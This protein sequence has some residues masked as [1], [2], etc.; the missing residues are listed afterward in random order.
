MSRSV[1]RSLRRGPARS[2]SFALSFA[3]PLALA[4]SLWLA[5]VGSCLY[6]ED[7]YYCEDMPNHY[8]AEA[9][10]ATSADCG[11]EAP[12][13]DRSAATGVCVQC[14]TEEASACTGAAP[15]CGDD[16]SCRGCARHGECASG[17]CLPDGACADEAQ[18]AYLA[19]GGAGTACTRGAPCANVATALALNK[20]VVK[21]SGTIADALAL[22]GGRRLTW[23]AEP[24]ARL[25]GPASG[26]LVTVRD[27]GTSLAMFDVT[28]AD[29]NDEAAGYGLLVAVDAGDVAVALQR[30]TV[31]NNRAGAISFS[32]GS[33]T[34][35]AS[36][37]IGNPGGG[38]AIA[39]NATRFSVRDSVLAYNGSANG[40]ASGLEPSTVGGVAI[41]AN[42]QGSDLSRNTIVYNQSDGATF[43]GGVSCNAPRATASGNLIFRNGEPDGAGDVRYDLA[44]QR[45]TTSACAYGNSLALASDAQNLGFASPLRPPLDFH[46]TAATPATVRDAGGDCSGRD[47]DGDPRP[48][49]GACDLG[50]D[51]YRPE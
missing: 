45:N 21:H 50:A 31:R 11:D 13:C 34:I 46:L 19:E 51:E 36:T 12:V 49:G 2:L 24:G 43:R 37:L 38:L 48:L 14:T 41:T 32:A 39:G 15:I 42:T 6:A 22:A 3:L 10:C 40:N 28:L 29:A 16:R 4:V 17:A 8:C 5:L 9:S 30:V 7:P 18:V 35:S 44:T 23:L 33:L 25:T 1:R 20:P 26:A 47:L 27:A